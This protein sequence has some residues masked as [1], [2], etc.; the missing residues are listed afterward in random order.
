MKK[1]KI[2]FKL[3]ISAACL[4]SIAATAPV[5][6]EAGAQTITKTK[7]IKGATLTYKVPVTVQVTSLKGKA[8]FKKKGEVIGGI[9]FLAY[10]PKKP[11]TALL[12]KY[13]TVINSR[14][15]KGTSLPCVRYYT[16]SEDFRSYHS[17]L[18]DAKKKRAFDFWVNSKKMTDKEIQDIRASI[19]VLK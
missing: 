12:P 13:E 16:Q 11:A 1:P 9:N 3:L 17:F 15:V 10:D 7:T 19:K 2:L 18:L 6:A 14:T 8:V 5:T 4:F